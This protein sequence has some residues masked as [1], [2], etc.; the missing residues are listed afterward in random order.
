MQIV[1]ESSCYRINRPNRGEYSNPDDHHDVEY[2]HEKRDYFPLVSLHSCHHF[3]FDQRSSH[4]C[5]DLHRVEVRILSK[6]HFDISLQ[7][8][9]NPPKTSSEASSKLAQLVQPTRRKKTR[10]PLRVWTNSPKFDALL[11]H[12]AS[13]IQ[14]LSFTGASFVMK[15]SIAI[16]TPVFVPR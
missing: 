8:F 1:L 6:N 9:S 16:V 14:M 10:G 13:A 15:S 7:A 4:E 3:P 2:Q 11:D 5:R 12:A